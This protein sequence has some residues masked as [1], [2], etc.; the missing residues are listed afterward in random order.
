MGAGST[1]A[2]PVTS[3][4]RVTIVAP[5]EARAPIS[6]RPGPASPGIVIETFALPPE[7]VV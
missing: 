1:A 7:F 6:W 5:F 3:N 4:D 2:E